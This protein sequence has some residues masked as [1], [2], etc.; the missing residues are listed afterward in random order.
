MKTRRQLQDLA[1]GAAL[2]IGLF[3]IGCLIEW[4]RG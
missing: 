2:L 4:A 1:I 3:L